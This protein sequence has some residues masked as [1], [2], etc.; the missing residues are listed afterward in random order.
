MKIQSDKRFLLLLLKIILPILVLILGIG[1]SWLLITHKTEVDEAKVKKVKH[2]PP[3]VVVTFAKQE[4]LRMDVSSQGVIEPRTEITLVSQVSGKVIK[5]HPAFAAGGYFKKG[6]TLL[7]IDPRDYEFAIIRTKAA[8][9]E[10]YKELLRER[11][12]ALQAEEEWQA[13]GSG[14]ASDYVLHKPQLKER[15]AKL[16]A[17]QAD[18]DAAK[19]Q[20]ERCRLL[21]PFEGWVR[22][23]RVSVGQYLN[24]EEKI[25]Q[26][27]AN[28][29]AEVRLPIPAEQLEFLQLPSPSDNGQT[30][31][32]VLLSAHQGSKE[33]HW[34]GRIVRTTSS[35]DDKNALLYAIAEIP[36]AFT[37]RGKQAPLMPGQFVRASISG[38]ERYDLLSL[39]KSAL[40][41][42]NQVYSVDKQ[43]KLKRHQV[44]ILRNENDRIIISKGIP[45]GERIV[46]DGIEL[47]V[48]GMKV[49]VKS[50]QQSQHT[51]ISL[52]PE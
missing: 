18:L 12:E 8:I 40:F 35:L 20:L 42:G 43:D 28:T 48:E 34:R 5:V 29:S 6:E 25:A 52:N 19:L 11:E 1:G 33:P 13:L 26:L 31:P 44:E 32:D 10:A 7:Q 41:G 4:T 37:A 47:P 49:K 51:A 46:I 27:Y 24:A 39:P 50:P 15:E 17:A 9:A 45:P 22:D 38:V 16:T 36:G 21:T 30:G 14:K 2:E 23:K 3:T